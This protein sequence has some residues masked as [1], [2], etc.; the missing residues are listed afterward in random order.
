MRDKRRTLGCALANALDDVGTK[1]DNEIAFVRT[2]ADLDP[3]HIRLLKIM[4]RRPKHLDQ[5]AHLMN[6]ADDPK[7][8]RQWYEWNIVEA[9]PVLKGRHGQRS[10]WAANHCSR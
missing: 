5:V 10:V 9:D 3:V 2:L 4:N 1:V 7:A 6:A 8:V